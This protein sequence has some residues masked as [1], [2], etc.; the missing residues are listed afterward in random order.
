MYQT[1]SPQ[2]RL[3]G[4]LNLRMLYNWSE[5]IPSTIHEPSLFV[6]VYFISIWPIM[7]F[8]HYFIQF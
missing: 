7:R 3:A 4:G 8:S 6:K 5:L 1:P 2:M